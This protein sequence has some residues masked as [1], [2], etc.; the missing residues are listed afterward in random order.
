[1]LEIPI[2]IVEGAAVHTILPIGIVPSWA[3]ANVS[4]FKFLTATT[5]RFFGQTDSNVILAYTLLCHLVLELPQVVL[6]GIA[7]LNS[8]KL[9]STHALIN[10]NL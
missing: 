5:L 8:E 4:A 7:F 10:E 2:G 6:D 3:L 9:P 1:M